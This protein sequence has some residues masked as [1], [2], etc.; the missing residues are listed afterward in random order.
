MQ[1]ILFPP[2]QTAVAIKHLF[3]DRAQNDLGSLD[4]ESDARAY[5]ATSELSKNRHFLLNTHGNRQL[6]GL[7]ILSTPA[8][9]KVKL[10]WVPVGRDNKW[11]VNC[12]ERSFESMS[13][14][15]QS[16]FI[17]NDIWKNICQADYINH[18]RERFKVKAIKVR[19]C[20]HAYI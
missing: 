17:G 10:N 8:V 20:K 12:I 16:W 7:E 5:Y 1:R 19:D 13:R 11:R 4:Y 2:T 3:S 9:K 15:V 18:K 14:L 6:P